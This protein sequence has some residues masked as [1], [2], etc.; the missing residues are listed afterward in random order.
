VAAPAL[1][2]GERRTWTLLFPRT[3]QDWI[4]GAAQAPLVKI[5]ATIRASA[6]HRLMIAGHTDARGKREANR[7]LGLERARIIADRLV[8][9]G[10]P[11]HRVRVHSMG[12]DRPAV[13][14]W[15]EQAWYKNRRVEI[16]LA[17]PSK[18]RRKE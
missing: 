5:A 18:G 7:E 8:E 3:R 6:G 13:A 15:N 11:R 17:P 14:G 9:L 2:P 4:P 1:D 10:V 16:A 12:E